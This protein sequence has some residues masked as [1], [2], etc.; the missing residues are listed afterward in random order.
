[1]GLHIGIAQMSR[2]LTLDL[3]LELAHAPAQP[4]E[5][6]A[7][8]VANLAGG[9]DHQGERALERAQIGKRLG[10]SR[11]A[12]RERGV[13]DQR[14]AHAARGLER[15]QQLCELA[16]VKRAA[17]PELCELDA[18]IGDASE[19]R[20]ATQVHERSRL[21]RLGQALAYTSVRCR[22]DARAQRFGSAH[23][24]RLRREAVEQTLP[25]EARQSRGVAAEAHGAGF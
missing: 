25:L 17:A 8:V 14:L 10:K 2:H 7:G 4:P 20:L 21:A 9:C 16:R 12:R 3:A 23:G 22:E 13:S 24:G 18:Q 15:R 11:E 1:M 5:V 6:W 19:S